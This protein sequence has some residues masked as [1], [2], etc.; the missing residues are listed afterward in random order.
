MG[1]LSNEIKKIESI[2]D[3]MSWINK[4]KEGAIAEYYRGDLATDR[5]RTR[6]KSE[7]MK[8]ADL[9]WK[10]YEVSKVALVQKRIGD[11]DYSYRM[12]SLGVR[13]RMQS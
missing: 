12:Q 2:E 10:A 8:I 5:Q 3:A 13:W 9:A 1:Q 11:N 7:Q 6:F 4:A